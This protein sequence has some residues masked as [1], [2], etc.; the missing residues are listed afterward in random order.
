VYEH[1][2]DCNEVGKKPILF[3]TTA[4]AYPRPEHRPS[5][6]HF[7]STGYQIVDVDH[8]NISYVGVSDRHNAGF[9]RWLEEKVLPKQ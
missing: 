7:N 5:L 2:V 9:E 1:L 8:N 4:L 6:L 3:Y